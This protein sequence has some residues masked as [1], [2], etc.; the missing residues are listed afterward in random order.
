MKPSPELIFLQ[1]G[2]RSMINNLIQNYAEETKRMKFFNK[3]LIG[4]IIVLLVSSNTLFAD[5]TIK[6]TV[7]D[8]ETGEPLPGAN[9]LVLGTLYG[10]SA[11]LE[12]NFIIKKIPNGVFTL[13]ISMIGYRSVTKEN[14]AVHEKET[15]NLTIEMKQTPIEFD[16]IVI[17]AGK[18][19]QRLDQASVSL[20]VVSAREIKQRSATNL[21]ESLETAPGIN[22]IG[23]QIN[24]R[25]S[26]GYT[27]GAG[28]KVLLL[29]DGVPVYASD[30][31]EFNWDMLPP[32]D[33]EQIE[34]LKGAGSTLWGASALGGVVNVI[35]KSP[36]P[37]G[38]FLFS[39][40]F[41]NYDEPY[42][43]TWEWTD[44][45]RQHYTRFDA[46]FSKRF[47]PFGMRISAGRFEST[48][49]TQLGDFTK[50]NLTGKFDYRFPGNI[51]WT[52]YGAYS[53]ID[54][55]F[56]VQ[57]KGQND[58]YEV[59]E[60]NLDNYAQTNQL[61]LYSKLAIPFSPRFAINLRA[62]MVRTI[63]GN[64]FG[65]SSDFNPAFGQGFEI[66][67]D[68]I[69]FFNHMITLGIQYQHDTGS[70]KFFGDHTGYFIGPYIQDEWKIRENLRLTTG[71]RYDRYQLIGG[72]KED[73]F[74]PRFGINWQPWETTS[75]RASAGSGFRAA[76][77][78]ERFL[79]LSIMNFKIIANPDLRAESSWAFD[80]GFRQYITE[81]WNIDVSFFDNEYWDM[82][83]AHMDLI[84]GQVQFR[85]I[86]R[87]RIQGIEATTKFSLPIKR[88][89]LKLTYDLQTSITA[90]H[91]EDLKWNE[92]LTYRPKLLATIKSIFHI[93]QTQLQ[94]DYRYA[95]KIEEVKI[96]P[97]NDRVP[98]K[99]LDYRILHDFGKITF[100]MGVKN[101]LQYNYAPMESNLMPMR[102]FTATL[103][104]EF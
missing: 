37:E 70:T 96:Y 69:P 2:L 61:N 100:Q 57:W 68:W 60:S 48:G 102:T 20:S 41:G 11:D 30:T 67:A 44:H 85:N 59:D 63:M 79:E 54:R 40:I 14:V 97:I 32:L 38:K 52:G 78:V 9:V 35:T 33:I 51:K 39:Y 25:G 28:N 31:G 53:Y 73:L 75:L 74:S 4:I 71:F 5:G 62:S 101:L 22:F 55:G 89:G 19:K 72:L 3:Y 86:T 66:Q 47:G 1:I 92:P 45:D 90:M 99:F 8:Q 91:H 46:S 12:G 76:T 21:I 49:Y 56:F 15:V 84:R 13:R 26:T 36:S 98:M 29:L 80:I 64:Q 87:A 7:K 77:I 95:S 23:N 27:F 6:G 94:L 10:A 42:Y 81:N 58:P 17:S 93:G 103:R 82:I 88:S 65:E 18:T 43:K 16:P 50:Y 83:E 24:I 34:V 104:G